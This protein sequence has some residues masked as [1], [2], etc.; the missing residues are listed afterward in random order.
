MSLE[1]QLAGLLELHHYCAACAKA[2]GI[3]FQESILPPSPLDLL[4]LLIDPE[5]SDLQDSC[6][7]VHCGLTWA[8]IRSTGLVGCVH[9]FDEF[10]QAIAKLLPRIAR[11]TIHAGSMPGQLHNFRRLFADK[12]DLNA[13]LEAALKAEDYENAARLRDVLQELEGQGGST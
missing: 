10:R 11:S 3:R 4:E 1:R 7:C 12:H 2:R 9:C 8:E 6:Q 13:R 5:G